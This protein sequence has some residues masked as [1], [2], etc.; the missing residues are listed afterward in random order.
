MITLFVALLFADGHAMLAHKDFPSRAA[1]E[2]DLAWVPGALM[3][4]VGA[5]KVMAACRANG[6]PV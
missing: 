1:C 6:E 5:I 2:A 4:K 3:E